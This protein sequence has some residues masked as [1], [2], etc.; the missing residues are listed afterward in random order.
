M[1]K[2]IRAQVEDIKQARVK[3]LKDTRAKGT[4]FTDVMDSSL[5]PREK[6]TARLSDEAAGVVG[7]GIETTKWAA[8]VTFFH[9]ID[10]PAVL[11]RLRR[12][13]KTAFPDPGKIPSLS[14]LEDVP[15]LMACIEEGISCHPILSE[16]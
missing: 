11:Q 9:I 10:N 5:P 7:A 16:A 15:Y 13:L 4:I 1:V 12:D 6:T 14:E 8:V 2:E 3:G